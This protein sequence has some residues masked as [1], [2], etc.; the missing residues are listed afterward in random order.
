MANGRRGGLSGK[1]RIYR[2]SERAS[3]AVSSELIE[4]FLEPRT[5]LGRCSNIRMGRRAD[6]LP[7]ALDAALMDNRQAQLQLALASAPAASNA[8]RSGVE[9]GKDSGFSGVKSGTKAPSASFDSAGVATMRSRLI[10]RF[11]PNRS[12]GSS[13]RFS[14]LHF[15]WGCALGGVA[16]ALLL[17]VAFAV[18]G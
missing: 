5:P 15:L 13:G 7:S 8:V 4:D 10:N 3:R 6:F 2:L 12:A 11:R 17:W 14:S 18:I 1:A 16:A 9:P